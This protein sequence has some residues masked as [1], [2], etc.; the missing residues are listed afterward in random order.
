[1]PADTDYR[2]ESVIVIMSLKLDLT[3]KDNPLAKCPCIYLKTG[4]WCFVALS[5]GGQERGLESDSGPISSKL[6]DLVPVTELLPA[7]ISPPVKCG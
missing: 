7:S 3:L 4:K 6:S 5:V 1:M 2:E